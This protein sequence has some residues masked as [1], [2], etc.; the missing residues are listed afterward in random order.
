MVAVVAVV[1]VSRALINPPLIV[2]TITFEPP[3]SF[4]PRSEASVTQKG[5]SL[6]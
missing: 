1:A 5:W 3:V 6:T 4:H 2:T